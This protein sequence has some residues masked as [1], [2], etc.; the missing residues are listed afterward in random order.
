MRVLH[1][2]NQL[3]LPTAHIPEAHVLHVGRD[4]GCFGPG[5][6][7]VVDA[8]WAL[9]QDMLACSY[10]PCADGPVVGG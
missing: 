4:H 3:C 6:V 10:V 1:G 9:G 7:N 8:H 5:Q 2:V